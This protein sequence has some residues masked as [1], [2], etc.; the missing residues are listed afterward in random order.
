M[1]GRPAGLG[2]QAP[3]RSEEIFHAAA[4]VVR[5]AI[6]E[7]QHRLAIDRLNAVVGKAQAANHKRPKLPSRRKE[8]IEH[9]ELI[10]IEIHVGHGRV[11]IVVGIVS[12]E[13]SGLTI[14]HE[15]ALEIL[16]EGDAAH[17]A[18]VHAVFYFQI[19]NVG[20][21]LLAQVDVAAK[22]GAE[23]GSDFVLPVFTLRID[24]NRR[25]EHHKSQQ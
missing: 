2:A 13:R 16:P 4:E 24:R 19:V 11:G 20:I 8:L 15:F 17:N 5:E 7:V 14:P 25:A 6:T 3:M 12:A 1:C 10:H 22:T 21:A 23:K 9:V 18:V